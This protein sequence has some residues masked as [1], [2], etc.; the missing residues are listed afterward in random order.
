MHP[1]TQRRLV[2]EQQ[3]MAA[4]LVLRARNTEFAVFDGEKRLTRW[5]TLRE[6]QRW[7]SYRRWPENPPSFL[8][9]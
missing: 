8:W 3:A 6:V 5:L 1:G 4:G 7:L 2:I 9:G